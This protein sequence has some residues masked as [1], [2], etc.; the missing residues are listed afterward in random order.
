MTLGDWSSVKAALVFC[1]MVS[2]HADY[3][4]VLLE[5]A[6]KAKV[7]NGEAAYVQLSDPLAF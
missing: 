4:N 3:L 6:G 1:V 7:R 5:R 2:F